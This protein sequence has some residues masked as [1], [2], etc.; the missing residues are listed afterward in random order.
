MLEIRPLQAERSAEEADVV[1]IATITGNAT[2]TGTANGNG[3][4]AL[5]A[6]VRQRNQSAFKQL[7][8]R[9]LGKIYGLCL[10][11]TANRQMAEDATQ[12]VFIQVW[13]KIDTFAGDSSF[14]TWLHA[15]ATNTT[16]S[17]L[18]KQKNWLA[19]MKGSDTYDELADQLVADPEAPLTDLERCLARLP[20]RARLVFVLHAIEGYRQDNIAQA[21]GISLGTV[22]AQ[23]HR[24]RY[25]IES[26]LDEGLR[27]I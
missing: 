15:L 24:A 21:M 7:Y 22:K 6:G 23:F 9:H 19:R 18:R 27:E 10:R 3:E 25:L 12:E 4:T 17:Y 26:C 13:R 1:V 16:I 2:A 20:E 8:D 14:S 11:M 5:I